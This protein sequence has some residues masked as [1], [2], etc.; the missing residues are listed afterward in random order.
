MSESVFA[1]CNVVKKYG[2]GFKNPCFLIGWLLWG[3][4]VMP[5]LMTEVNL[6]VDT[7]FIFVVTTSPVILLLIRTFGSRFTAWI[8]RFE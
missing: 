2:Y 6:H 4:A 8:N 1:G 7:M 5:Y 3:S